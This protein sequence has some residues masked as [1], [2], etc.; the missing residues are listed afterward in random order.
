[1]RV[2]K[3]LKDLDATDQDLPAGTKP[4][5]SDS[6]CPYCRGLWNETK[7]LWNKKKIFSYFTVSGTVRITVHILMIRR[8]SSQTRIFQG[9]D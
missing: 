8:S 5:I 2:K 9:F 4:F 6:Q 1:M 3:D 7:K